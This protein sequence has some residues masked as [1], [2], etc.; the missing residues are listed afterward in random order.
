MVHQ[1]KPVFFVLLLLGLTFAPARAAER[2]QVRIV[3]NLMAAVKMPY[4]EELHRYKAR[5]ERVW[6]E[7]EGAA[8]V[9]CLSNEDRIWCYE[10]IPAVG[11]RAEMLR[12]HNQA[13]GISV[14]ALYHYM[15]DYDLDGLI[16]VGST[17][18]IEGTPRGPIGVII[19][20]FHRSTGR[21]GQYR[22]D[23]QKMYD[24]GIQLALKYLGE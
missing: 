14:G 16:D 5:T 3:V 8:T 23:Y 22:A 19:Q 6:L 2:E 12:I 18:K 11:N 17:T 1:S 20:F 7:H 21:G 4:P 13:S 15:V 24:D 10:H 9:A